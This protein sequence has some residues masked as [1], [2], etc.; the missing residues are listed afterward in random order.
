M[1]FVDTN[2]LTAVE[3]RPGWLE[4]YFH[5]PSMT[6]AH[7]EFSGGS[8]IHKHHHP[9]EEVWEIL[10]GTLEVT[11][12]R[13]RLRLLKIPARPASTPFRQNAPD[14]SRRI[15]SV[16]LGRDFRHHLRTMAGLHR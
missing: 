12:S 3:R 5:S 2:K 1:P 4:K 14:W 8:Y 13:G 9:Q 11:Y 16:A 7:W 10:A 15:E 6:F